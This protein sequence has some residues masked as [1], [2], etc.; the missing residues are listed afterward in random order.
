[1]KAV[2]SHKYKFAILMEP[3]NTEKPYIYWINA[4]EESDCNIAYELVDFTRNDWEKVFSYDFDMLLISPPFPS[5]RLKNLFDER[6]YVL[7]YLMNK[8]MYP[9]FDAF[10]SYENKRL[11][12]YFLEALSIPHS[13]TYVFYNKLEALEHV[14]SL[15]H[16]LVAKTIIGAAGLGV[17]VLKN[18]NDTRKYIQKAFNHGIRSKTG[19]DL[20]K[21][22]LFERI[23]RGFKIKGYVKQKMLNYFRVIK[24]KQ[25]GYVYLQEFI[26]HSYEWR[27]VRIDE[28]YFA[29]K[30]I[31]QNEMASG[32]LIKKY[33]N[34]PTSLLTFVKKNSD[35][36]NIDSAA[37]DIFEIDD[38]KYLINEIQ[39]I[40]GQ[41]DPYQMLIDNEPGRYIF[42]NKV[43]SF[44]KGNFNQNKSYN[45]RLQ[46]AIKILRQDKK[47]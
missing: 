12:S 33:D 37:F 20:R 41:S 6:L 8:K 31:V 4:I 30:K 19:P 42:K 18:K 21:P 29:H 15:E 22:Q 3:S 17:K 34:P 16:P 36:I 43:W 5:M 39:T 13:K 10:F 32:Y 23:K 38:G 28:S 7:H 25:V 1:M 26:P 46:H 9:S 35:R 11:L 14:E 2:S 27:C 40:F 45:L 47:D 24:D 44:E